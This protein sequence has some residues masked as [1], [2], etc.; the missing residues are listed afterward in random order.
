M[1]KGVDTGGD[2]ARKVDWSSHMA[3]STGYLSDLHNA[4]FTGQGMPPRQSEQWYSASP[5]G[6]SGPTSHESPPKQ[7][8]NTATQGGVGGAH[9]SVQDWYSANGGGSESTRYNSPKEKY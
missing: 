6:G 7:T 2:E 4:Q 1:P 3:R 8:L 9:P 5:N